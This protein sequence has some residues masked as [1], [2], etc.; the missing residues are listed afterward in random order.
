M[1][2]TDFDPY[3]VQQRNEDLRREVATHRLARR[4]R[5]RRRV[6]WRWALPGKPYAAELFLLLALG[7]VAVTSV[8]AAR[9]ALA[10]PVYEVRELGPPAAEDGSYAADVNDAGRVIGQSTDGGGNNEHALLWEDGQARDLGVLPGRTSSVA[11]GTNDSGQVVGRSGLSAVLWEN[12]AVRDLNDLIPAGSGWH[13][14]SASA[15]NEFGQIAGRGEKNGQQ[16]AFLLTHA[17]P[18]ETKVTSGPTGFT[19]SMSATF[20][21]SSTEA[22]A[23]FECS[24]DGA[25]LGTCSS[26][27]AYSGLGSGKHSF[28]V[29]ATDAA[30]N[31]DPIPA[32]RT[33]TVD[34]VKPSV[35]GASPRAGAKIRDATPIVRA[36]VK[37]SQANLLKNNV[38]LYVDGKAKRFS[39]SMSTDRLTHRSKKLEPGRHTVR[40]VAKDAAG[41]V[42]TENWRFKVTRR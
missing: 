10:T 36:L 31:A 42:A 29:R 3:L 5:R 8:V 19:R 18:P 33:W 32:T 40:I 24:L 41:N 2:L 21:F 39:Y 30:G 14:V 16:R 7:I 1:H 37:D 25:S 34:R 4:R 15:V 23:S 12:G 22:S 20:A 27:K 11:L 26:P 17:S 9:P 28:E 13:L 38:K 6:P 35:R